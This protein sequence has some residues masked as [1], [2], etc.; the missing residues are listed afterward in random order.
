MKNPLLA[1][2]ALVAAAPL[3]AGDTAV[4]YPE[5][6][7]DWRHVKTM[8]IEQGHPLYDSFGG[9]H[10]LYANAPALEGYRS[11]GDFPD[12]SVIIFDLFEAVQLDSA[13]IEG[14]HKVVGVMH[15]DAA[16]FPDTGGWG[17]EGFAGGDPD[18]RVVKDNAAS[19]CFGCHAPQK[20]R[21]YVFS[22]L[23]RGE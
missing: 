14:K 17:F 13:V 2:L 23:R 22:S 21:D 12:G 8:V 19:A 3:Q 11:A 1:V 20:K 16:R 7:R 18:R 9:I 5:G 10:H 4:P 6:Y 15:K